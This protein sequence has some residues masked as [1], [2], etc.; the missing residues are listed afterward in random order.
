VRPVCIG[1]L[2]EKLPNLSSR[3]PEKASRNG[4][5]GFLHLQSW[6]EMGISVWQLLMRKMD[7]EIM[8][9]LIG[10][11]SSGAVRDAFA[12][13]GHEA[14]SCDLLATTKPGPHYQ[15]DVFD[16]LD[17]P[18]DLAI[19]HPPCTHLSVSGAR[20]FEEKRMDGRQQAGVSFFL[21]LVR[22]SAHIPKRV[23]E[24]PVSIMSSMWRKPDQIIQPWMFGHGETKATCLWLEGL[25]PLRAT[26][27]VEGREAR[28]HKMP[29]SA[30]R[31]RL[32]SETYSGIANAMAN[33]WGVLPESRQLAI[34]LE[35]A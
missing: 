10:C 28:I 27:I 8:R 32:R 5:P 31:W 6:A 30:D 25:Q 16:V 14:M 18:W 12:A 4:S 2:N 13:M 9:V 15:G 20:H 24:N 33:Q 26:E 34:D 11:E 23:F 17:Y 22:C 1:L 19:F 29:S 21:K 35:A 3:K 7:G